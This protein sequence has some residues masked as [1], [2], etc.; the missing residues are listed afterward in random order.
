MLGLVAEGRSSK[1]IAAALGISVRTAEAH[2]DSIAKKTGL[3]SVAALTRL[4]LG[5]N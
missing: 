3:R 4:V 2:R 1:E 5:D